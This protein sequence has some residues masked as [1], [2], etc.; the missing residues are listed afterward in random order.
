[1]IF[2]HFKNYK[3]IGVSDCPPN[4]AVHQSI[5]LKSAIFFRIFNMP[6]SDTGVNIIEYLK[7]WRL[8]KSIHSLWPSQ[9]AIFG[10]VGLLQTAESRV[11]SICSLRRIFPP[12]IRSSFSAGYILLEGIGMHSG[13]EY[14]KGAPK[15]IYGAPLETHLGASRATTIYAMTIFNSVFFT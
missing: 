11:H 6:D 12:E 4:T 15:I 3:T 14:G 13:A 10:P 5:A 8:L 9:S 7:I 2:A 1:M